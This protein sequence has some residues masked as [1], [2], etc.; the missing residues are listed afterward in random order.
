MTYFEWFTKPESLPRLISIGDKRGVIFMT[1]LKSFT[2][3]DSSPTG[4]QVNN[5]RG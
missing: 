5:N 3:L 4:N 2:E 1:D